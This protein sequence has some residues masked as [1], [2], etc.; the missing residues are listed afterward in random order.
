MTQLNI[1][2]EKFNYNSDFIPNN[3][4]F[5]VTN[6]SIKGNIGI[7]LF[8]P[9]NIFEINGNSFFKGNLNIKETIYIESNIT[10]KMVI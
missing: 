5:N 2:Y 10:K 6:S 8:N 7:N 9:K 1:N 4:V 3:N